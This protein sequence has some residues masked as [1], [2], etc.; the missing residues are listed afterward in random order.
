MSYMSPLRKPRRGSARQRIARAHR[1]EA[2]GRRTARRL[3][4]ESLEE[5][6][7]LNAAPVATDDLYRVNAGQTLTVLF[8]QGVLAND[9]DP[10]FPD[11]RDDKRFADHSS[12]LRA[13][14]DTSLSRPPL[15]CAGM[16]TTV[17]DLG[18]ACKACHQDFRG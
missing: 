6:A 8:P 10:A 3:R 13:S 7:L 11:L 14:L 18:E 4:V 9:L 5:R 12:K 16:A 17:Q 2:F 1:S 15:N